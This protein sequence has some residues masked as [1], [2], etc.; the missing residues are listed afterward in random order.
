MAVRWERLKVVAIDLK[1]QDRTLRQWIRTGRAVG[2][3]DGPKLLSV[4]VRDVGVSK[5]RPVT[6]AEAEALGFEV[7]DLDL[8][9]TSPGRP[10]PQPEPD[11]ELELDELLKESA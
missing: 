10:A 2:R 9:N 8:E 3:R 5:G 1:V 4:L 7:E 6:R 11:D